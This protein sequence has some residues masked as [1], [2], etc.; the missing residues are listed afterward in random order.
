M[1]KLK[2]SGFT[3]IELMIAI[4]AFS[5]ILMVATFGIINIGRM[6][7]KNITTSRTQE[8]TRQVV[9]DISSTI[10]LTGG[11]PDFTD[12]PDPKD[13][14]NFGKLCL[15]N[16]IRYIFYEN[17]Q[18][19][20]GSGRGLI[21]QT[22]VP[23]DNTTNF[24]G[25]ELLAEN[26]RLLDLYVGPQDNGYSIKARV[27]YGDNDLLTYYPQNASATT[28]PDSDPSA[29]LCRS[30]VAGGNFCGV[31]ELETFVVKRVN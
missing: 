20:E 30:G 27:A 2:N 5:V 17:Y 12:D 15:G 26:M 9:Q 4:T 21:R 14:G 31:S 10:Q 7:Y 18:L 24:D 6:Y 28:P 11:H 22:N 16:N 29:G 3:L 1:I 13:N 8:A 25:Q 19:K 23:C